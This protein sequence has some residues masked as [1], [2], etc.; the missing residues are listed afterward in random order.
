LQTKAALVL[1]PVVVSKYSLAK[2]RA[3]RKTPLH[4]LYNSL[5]VST[6]YKKP[7]AA[8]LMGNAASTLVAPV[9]GRRDCARR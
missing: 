4:N 7:G 5:L 9:G 1:R 6:K 8:S 3:D 2:R